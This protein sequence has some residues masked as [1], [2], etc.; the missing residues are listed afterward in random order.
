MIKL[1]NLD[2]LRSFSK[3]I[4]ESCSEIRLNQDELEDMLTAIDKLGTRYDK[5]S[6]SKDAFVTNDR[7]LRRETLK[8]VKTI[9]SNVALILKL[10]DSINNEIKSQSI[11]KG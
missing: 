6:V 5:G 1:I 8:M 4:Y 11:K 2:R 7:R 9:D 10:L 3:R